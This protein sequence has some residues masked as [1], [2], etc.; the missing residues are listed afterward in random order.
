MFGTYIEI[1]ASLANKIYR[2]HH[3]RPL[4]SSYELVH[5][6]GHR[7]NGDPHTRLFALADNA[8]PR[9]SHKRIME[10][11]ASVGG[12]EL[13]KAY[14][15]HEVQRRFGKYRP[16]V[17]TQEPEEFGKEGHEDIREYI[18]IREYQLKAKRTR[19]A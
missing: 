15:Q 8:Q 12:V 16:S 2:R 5:H 19:K 10:N 4:K 13:Q 11:L 14:L 3:I 18:K 9:I 6:V 1:P 7:L 17:Y